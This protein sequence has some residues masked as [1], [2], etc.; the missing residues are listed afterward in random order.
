ML[1]IKVIIP[2]I[3]FACLALQVAV[4][5]NVQQ[6]NSQISAMKQQMSE[7]KETIH[8]LQT[9]WS[10][11]TR[12]ERIARLEQRFLKLEETRG[13][14]LVELADLPFS[15]EGP[16]RLAEG[17]VTITPYGGVSLVSAGGGGAGGWY[18]R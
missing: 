12:P 10:Y 17:D 11:L 3:L 18:A 14:Q 4:A 1:H 6:I 15:D 5:D 7:E 13:E 9:E 2:V 8:V 16:I